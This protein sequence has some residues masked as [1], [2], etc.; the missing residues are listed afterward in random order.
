MKTALTIP[1]ATAVLLA[2]AHQQE[3]GAQARGTASTSRA[4]AVE[5]LQRS[6][7][8]GALVKAAIVLASSENPGD[9]AKLGEFLRQA[10][11]LARL[12]DLGSA[13]DRTRNL[14]KILA[15]L[16]EHPSVAA[17]RVCLA[18]ATDPVFLSNDDRRI[19]LLP[20]LGAVRPMSEEGV[21]VFRRANQDGYDAATPP[22][23][24]KNGSPRALALFEEMI[25]DRTAS[26]VRRID[27]LHA[28]I[29]P[30]RTNPEVLG[31][32]ERILAAPLEPE[33]A[34]GAIESV[35]D[36][37]SRRWFGVSRSAPKP[38]PWESAPKDALRK[39]LALAD[40]ARRRT[41]GPELVEA[42]DRTVEAVKRIMAN[43]PPPV[44]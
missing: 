37:Q 7:D 27:A 17:E 13:A 23:L 39:V 30:W 3:V 24:A 4:A 44:E 25:L 42:I 8:R 6:H 12:D 2:A 10:G 38:P 9:V 31:S 34:S 40:N 22:L 19:Y 16:A 35:F 1:L 15:A 18:L 36:D 28:S 5:V 32:V 20:A 43:S 26:M 11:F 29:V 14:E 21:A 41:L 33:V